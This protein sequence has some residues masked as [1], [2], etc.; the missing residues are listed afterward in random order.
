MTIT[1]AEPM[2]FYTG[3][4]TVG[5]ANYTVTRTGD[6]TDDLT[7]TVNLTQTRPYLDDV[8]QSQKLSRTVTIPAGDTSANLTVSRSALRLS[9]DA[10]VA[11]GTLTATVVAPAGYEVGANASVAVVIQVFMTVRF[12]QD[13]HGG[14]GAAGTVPVTLIAQTDTPPLMQPVPPSGSPVPVFAFPLR[15]QYFTESDTAR[16]DQDFVVVGST[17]VAFA[18]ADF[19]PVSTAARHGLAGGKDGP[20][21][22]PGRLRWSRTTRRS[23]SGSRGTPQRTS[24][25]CW[26]TPTGQIRGMRTRR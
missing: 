22:D 19:A 20:R 3:T 21:D 23:W 6:L 13:Y 25:S 11:T 14:G 24:V 5:G 7:V 26:W 15:V 8:E 9:A 10:E 18:A 12:E 2:L 4:G 16:F 17:V 1:T